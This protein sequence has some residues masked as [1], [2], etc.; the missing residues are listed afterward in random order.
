MFHVHFDLFSADV[1]SNQMEAIEQEID[2]LNQRLV[3][4]DDKLSSDDL[5]DFER[6]QLKNR[7]DKLHKDLT[8]YK[9]SLEKLHNR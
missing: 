5:S 7:F 9:E 3:Q 2:R 4:I 8:S 1:K 6:R